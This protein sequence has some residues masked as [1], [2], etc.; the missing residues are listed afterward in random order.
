MDIDYLKRDCGS[1]GGQRRAVE[2][3]VPD[4]V[5][6]IT[7]A[8]AVTFGVIPLGTDGET[9][10][11]G[12]VPD[13]HPDCK[14]ALEGML[15]RPIVTVPFNELVIREAITHH[16]LS[17][18][19]AASPGLDLAT[20]ESPEFLRDAAS[21]RRLMSEKE[22]VLPERDITVP[23]GHIA[24]MD[25]RAHSVLRSLDR[26]RR[27]EFAPSA[28]GIPFKLD[29]DGAILYRERMPGPKVRAIL[30]QSLF[31]DGDEH[32]HALKGQDL[33]ILPHVLHPSELQLAE[34]DGDE[35]RFWVYDKLET[36]RASSTK[37]ARGLASW[38][39]TYY[40]L[41]FGARFMRTLRVDVLSFVLVKRSMLRV[42]K[43]KDRLVPSDLKRLFGLDFPRVEAADTAR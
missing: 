10:A 17:S 8:G 26:D 4:V 1:I 11:F 30:A 16:Y 34:L 28:S 37:G 5:S 12:C 24:L 38:N 3:L 33:E 15:G 40:F 21:V 31:Y 36:V 27:V 20:F 19:G 41:H 22:G 18:R 2:E 25:L 39:C 43:R 42:A 23:A 14:P 6:S 9:M 35:A 13:L 29:G 7:P 32:L